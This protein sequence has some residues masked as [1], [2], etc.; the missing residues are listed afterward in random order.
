MIAGKIPIQQLRELNRARQKLDEE[1]RTL[2][3]HQLTTF[4]AIP[5]IYRWTKENTTD[6][7]PM[8]FRKKFIFIILA[9]FSVK[10][11]IGERMPPNLRA[12]I[13][14]LFPELNTGSSITYCARCA[15]VEYLYYADFQEDVDRLLG[16]LERETLNKWQ[17]C[18]TK[19]ADVKRKSRR[20]RRH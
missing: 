13:K 15:V 10:A 16:L 14:R 7:N 1:E 9:L 19:P 17:C 3:T 4:G 18:S 6:D 20:K 5:E 11:L 8:T 2:T 12:E